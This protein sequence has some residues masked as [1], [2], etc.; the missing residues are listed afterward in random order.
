MAPVFDAVRFSAVAL[1]V[2]AAGHSKRDAIAARQ[3]A[4]LLRLLKTAAQGSTLYR[5]RLKGFST[6]TMDLAAIPFVTKHELMQRF[7]QWV[8]DPAL[9]LPELREFLADP[10]CI[11]TPYLGKYIVWESSGSGG[12]PG[13]FVQDAG[14]MATYDA[15]EAL[16]RSDPQ[17]LQRWLVDPLGLSER[18]AFVAATGGHFAS[19]VSV[20][21]LR[22]LNP[23]MAQTIRCF[24]ILQPSSALIAQLNEFSPTI[25][26][27]Y[28][29]VAALLADE[30]LRGSLHIRPREIL[31]GGETLTPAVRQRL[32]RVLGA[33]VRNNYGASEFLSIAWECAHGHLHVNE[34]WVILEPVDEKHRPVPPGEPSHSCLLTNLANTVQSLIRYDLSDQITVSA[35]LCTCGSPLSVIEVVGRTDDALI[36]RGKN[37]SNVTLLPLALTTVLEELADL[38]DFQLRQLDKSKLELNLHG[39]GNDGAAQWERGRSVLQAFA[40]SQGLAPIDVTGKSCVTLTRGRSGKVQRVIASRQKKPSH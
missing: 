5:E 32:E 38:F 14:A 35:A 34:D 19:Y 25:I 7:D 10:A 17:R 3:H 12:P 23:W 1:D 13:V 31:T 26:A 27:T 16:R 2:A 36:M 39:I 33:I 28:P 30:A 9:T 29:T 8:S 22:Q 20:Q 11:G 21:R 24:S 4:R 40:Q 18:T 15:L 37:G 6:A